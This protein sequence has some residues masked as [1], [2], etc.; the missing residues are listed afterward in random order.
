[1]CR[2]S[3]HPALERNAGDDAQ[4]LRGEGVVLA[5]RVPHDPADRGPTLAELGDWLA[6]EGCVDALNLDG[7]PSTAAAFHRENG[8]LNIGTGVHLPYSIRFFP[9]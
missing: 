3:G 8:V 2:S 9:R 1:L 7:G 4:D 6:A 5:R